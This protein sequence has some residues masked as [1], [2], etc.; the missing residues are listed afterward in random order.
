[1]RVCRRP[2][3]RTLLRKSDCVHCARGGRVPVLGCRASGVSVLAVGL[4]LT[5]RWPRRR[6]SLWWLC[7]QHVIC[8]PAVRTALSVRAVLRAPVRGA[9]R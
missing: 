6:L 1:M 8:S 4:L 5:D 9:Q 7:G 3:S 2:Y